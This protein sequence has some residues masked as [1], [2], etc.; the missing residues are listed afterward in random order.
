MA[1]ETLYDA[2]GKNEPIISGPMRNE[3]FITRKLNGTAYVG[4]IVGAV[5]E[6][7]PDVDQLADNEAGSQIG[8]II[9]PIIRPSD[10]WN[11]S[12]QLVDDTEVVILLFGTGLYRTK[13]LIAGQ[14]SP[15][16]GKL[17]DL[18]YVTSTDGQ[19]NDSRDGSATLNSAQGYAGVIGRLAEDHTTGN[20]TSAANGTYGEVFI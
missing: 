10:N 11:A 14:D 2:T 9:R 3:D 20:S 13:M 16:S 7:D 8:Q 12:D 15:I 4:D 5:G 1:D 17:G 18:V 19:T 6:T